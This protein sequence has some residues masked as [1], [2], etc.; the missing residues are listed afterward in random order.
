M[1]EPTPVLSPEMTA[2][3]A[4]VLRE[5]FSKARSLVEFGCGGSTLM[6][7]RSPPLQRIWSVESDVAWIAKLRAQAEIADAERGGRLRFLPIDLGPVGDHGQPADPS[8]QARWPAYSQ[9]VWAIRP[10]SPPTWC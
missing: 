6:A 10:R 1:A 5:C 3:E 4:E 7:V 2:E 8:T 9:A